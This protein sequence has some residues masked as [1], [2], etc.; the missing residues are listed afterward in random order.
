MAKV[1][2]FYL[3]KK[4]KYDKVLLMKLVRVNVL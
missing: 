4:S 2:V 1:L 3:Q